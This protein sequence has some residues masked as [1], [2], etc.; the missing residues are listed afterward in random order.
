MYSKIKYRKWLTCAV[1]ISLLAGFNM[2]EAATVQSTKMVKVG[3]NL[4]DSTTPYDS[5]VVS[6]NSANSSFVISPTQTV[7]VGIGQDA[8]TP[9]VVYVGAPASGTYNVIVT[10]DGSTTTGPVTTAGVGSMA[11]GAVTVYGPLAVKVS[12]TGTVGDSADA[13]AIGMAV[14]N[15]GSSLVTENTALSVTAQG[16]ISDT[17]AKAKAQGVTV[18]NDNL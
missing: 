18:G 11:A 14:G 16:G 15:M 5:I 9:L 1:T 13:N 4:S 17:K 8:A 3:N 12:S 2:T 7:F 6:Q 10:N